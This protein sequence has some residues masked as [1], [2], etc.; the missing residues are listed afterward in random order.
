M[1]L[2]ILM[3]RVS[4]IILLP[5]FNGLWNLHAYVL[6]KVLHDFG[7]MSVQDVFKAESDVEICQVQHISL[8]IHL[9]VSS[10]QRSL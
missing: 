4:I 8:I 3:K 10:K 2:D 9:Q 1:I 7:I 5:S 6:V